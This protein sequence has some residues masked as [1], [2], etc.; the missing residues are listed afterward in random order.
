MNERERILDL[1]KQGVISSEEALLLL[2]N[3]AKQN[4]TKTSADSQPDVQPENDDDL[5]DAEQALSEL[6]TQIAT[7]SGNLA[8]LDTQL[9]GLRK[10][11]A[12]NEE[13]IIVLDTME[14]LDTLT[15]EKYQERGQ[16]K[17]ENLQ[18]NQQITE[19]NQQRPDLQ[20]QL[21]EL[22]QQKRQLTKRRLSDVLPDDWQD[23]AR[24]TLNDFGSTMRDASSQIAHLVKDT[25]GNVMDNVD[26]KDITI[27]VPGL[28]TE[29]FSQSFDYPDSQATILDLKVANGDV[30]FKPWD[31]DGFKIDADI[32]LYG[33]F[34]EATPL[35]AFN[36]RARIEVNDDHLIFQVPNKRV[37]ADLTVYFP[38]RD[39]DHVT[40]RL[41][42]GSVIFNQIHGK[43]FYVKSTNGDI[44]FN[45]AQ[46]VM[47][48]AQGVNGSLKVDGGSVHDVFLET[49]NG[50]IKVT[51]T[52]Q[53]AQLTTVNG[54]I[55]GTYA[56]AFHTLNASSVN[57]NVKLAFPVAAALNGQVKT[58]FGAVKSRLDQV[59]ANKGTK[60][61]D[62]HR[63]GEGSG[64]V[65][66]STTSG[67]ILLKDTDNN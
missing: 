38:A 36:E 65:T 21:A 63:D 61:L 46:V 43:D 51:A 10:Q 29:K 37:S 3:L 53:T 44:Q 9:A 47:I 67:T 59:S 13:Q 35:D 48:E 58:R 60:A 24:D 19:L 15:Q 39:Y 50:D 34:N 4:E 2:E 56:E 22:E 41:L 52:P 6:N 18:L 31:Q 16:L 30:V 23:Q 66:V 49:V 7:V 8:A 40:V 20:S 12:A 1:V 62:L 64:E 5:D 42:N 26:W 55:R 17:Q 28:A 57:G 25:V 32:K 11:V 14:D 27:K 45:D 33:K 54:T